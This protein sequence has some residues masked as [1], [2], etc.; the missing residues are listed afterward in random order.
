MSRTLLSLAGFQVILSGR[1]WVIAEATSSFQSGAAETAKRFAL[2]GLAIQLA[3]AIRFLEALTVAQR[4][5]YATARD[6][7]APFA[8]A[9]LTLLDSWSSPRRKRK[10]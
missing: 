9:D 10:K 8:S 7:T 2:R 1:F 6:R 5:K 4:N 3:D